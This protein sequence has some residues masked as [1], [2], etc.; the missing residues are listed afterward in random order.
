MRTPK[1]KYFNEAQLEVQK[2]GANKT[3]VIA[4]RG[5][6]KSE[7]ID[8]PCLVRNI[9]AMPG[10]TGALISPTYGKLLRNTLPAVCRALGSMGY[11]RDFH[12]VIGKAPNKR[13]NYGKP[14]VE[15][16]DYEYV[17]IWHNGTI[18]Q[19]I[20][21]DRPMSANSMSLDWFM[22]FEAKYIDPVKLN[23]E[24]KPANRGLNNI[25]L[26]GDCPWWHGETYTS[27]M[28]T[29][30]NGR[31]L[32]DHEKA[33]DPELIA[34]IIDT[35][36]ERRKYKNIIIPKPYHIKQIKLLTAELTAYRKDA[37]FYAEYDVFENIELLGEEWVEQK[38]RELPGFIFNTSILNIRPGKIVNGFYSALNPKIHYYSSYDNNYLD[39]LSYNLDEAQKAN[40]IKDGDINKDLP[41]RVALDYN[42]SINN[43]VCGQVIGR[44]LRTLNWQF[45]KTPRKIKE[46]CNDWCDYYDYHPNRDVIYFFDSTAINDS[47]DGDATPF[48]EIVVNTLTARGWNVTSV[49][50]GKPMRHDKKHLYFD[51]AFKGHEDFLFPTFNQDNCEFLL[52]AMEQTGVKQGRNGFEKDKDIEKT[53][54]TPN[55]PDEL[56]T[57]GTDAWD[58]LF[59][60]SNFHDVPMGMIGVSSSFGK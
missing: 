7:G 28:P 26:F 20:S 52:L 45:V 25:D 59:I 33:M 3:T 36:E 2:I 6:G 29:G 10:S 54:D 49:Y 5:T 24:V 37:H 21:F 39:S 47:A 50:I 55:N 16:I 22:I 56:K 11:V 15:P 4:S 31:F 48:H 60:G 35:F 1:K 30:K 42:S 14:I 40:C 57:H 32:F 34:A 44:E 19:M 23:E 17:L 27:D 43:V 12:Y 46:V 13:L 41:L 51:Y 9:Y 8:A 18:V 53:P 58:T 38:K